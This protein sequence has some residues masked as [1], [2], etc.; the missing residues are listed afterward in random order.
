M[1]TMTASTNRIE[2]ITLARSGASIKESGLLVDR[3]AGTVLI[4]V[5]R[6]VTRQR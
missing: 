4:D 1:M 3:R 6:V 2:P 5:S